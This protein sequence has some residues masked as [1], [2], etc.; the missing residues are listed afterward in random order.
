[1]ESGN[2]ARGQGQPKQQLGIWGSI[3]Q[4]LGQGLGQLGNLKVNINLQPINPRIL[5]E[6]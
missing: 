4:G 3:G 6:N 5:F 2:T 1:M